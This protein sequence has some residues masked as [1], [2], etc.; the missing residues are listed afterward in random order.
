MSPQFESDGEASN[1]SS[2]EALLDMLGL[3]S[4]ESLPANAAE[5]VVSPIPNISDE[6]LKDLVETHGL[7][8]RYKHKSLCVLPPE[9]SISAEHMRR[10]T[11]E[12]VWGGDSVQADRTYETVTVFNKGEIYPKKC[13]T[14]LEHFVDAHSAWSELCHNHLRRMVSA[15][16]GVEMVLYKEKLNLKPP[17]GSGF[18]PHLDTPSLRV[19]LGPKGPQAFCTVMVAIDDMTVQN[20]CL[21]VCKGEW[22]EDH[23]VETIAPEEDGNPDAGGR[24][25][26]IPIEVA[27]SLVFDNLVCRGGTIAIFNGWAPH[28]SAS[29]KSP[30]PRRA[31]FLTYNP[32]EE[33]DFHTRYYERMDEVRQEWRESVGLAN[34]KQREEDEKLEMEALATIPNI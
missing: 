31:V 13:L 25:G 14:R 10:L 2:D 27:D 20:G 24:A 12:L 28:R 21:R 4:L 11:E 6:E 17:G 33:G 30:F 15:A 23:C 16:L 8:T 26:A 1:N 19:A 5:L 3:A 7:S 9:C 29:N 34:R 22:T 32:K 18:A